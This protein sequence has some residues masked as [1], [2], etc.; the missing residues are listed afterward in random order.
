[1]TTLIKI[2]N[3]LGIR[4]P[5]AYIKKTKLQNKQLTFE[6]LK[7]GLLIKPVSTNKRL[8][9]ENKTKV[10]MQNNK[11]ECIDSAFLE[12]DLDSKEWNEAI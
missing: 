11:D 9:W 1:M 8:D 2:G 6:I 10:A 12:F 4:I 5:K 3:S 7:D